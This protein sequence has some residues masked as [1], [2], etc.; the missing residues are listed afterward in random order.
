MGAEMKPDANVTGRYD[1][2]RHH[3]RTKAIVKASGLNAE[4]HHGS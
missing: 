4:V 3:G 1:K 2:E